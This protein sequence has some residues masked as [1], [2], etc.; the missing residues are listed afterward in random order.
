MKRRLLMQSPNG[1]HSLSLEYVIQYWVCIPFEFS[2]IVVVDHLGWV[3]MHN[4]P[5]N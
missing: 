3:N 5:S 2:H 1:S 4:K